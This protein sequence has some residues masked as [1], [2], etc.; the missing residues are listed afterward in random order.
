VR[1]KS[2][3]FDRGDGRNGCVSWHVQAGEDQAEAVLSQALQVLTR[4]SAVWTRCR[5]LNESVCAS[6]SAAS[7]KTT[8]A[9]WNS[10]GQSR[11][12]LLL[13]PVAA[14]GVEVTDSA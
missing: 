3:V 11:T 1:G 5:R 4:T 8:M 13:I 12:E 2:A 9:V 10:L 6:T 7:A 14:A